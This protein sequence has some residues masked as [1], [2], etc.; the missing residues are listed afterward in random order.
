MY[1]ILQVEDLDATMELKLEEVRKAFA[2]K[3]KEREILAAK[4]KEREILDEKNRRE[5]EAK[6]KEDDV[7]AQQDAFWKQIKVRDVTCCC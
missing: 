2:A 4:K 6:K 5:E 3:K 1:C 7:Q